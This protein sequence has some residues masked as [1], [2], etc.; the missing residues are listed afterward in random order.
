MHK[1]YVLWDYYPVYY[2]KYGKACKLLT[3]HF[4]HKTI[5]TKK[6]LNLKM[7]ENLFLKSTNH[8]AMKKIIQVFKMKHFS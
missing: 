6:P 2:H 5:T 7:N 4:K 3:K 8:N 1:K